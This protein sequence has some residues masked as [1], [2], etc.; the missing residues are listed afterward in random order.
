MWS[1]AYPAYLLVVLDPFTSIFRY[2]IPL[3]PL[4]A[5]LI[6]AAGRPLWRRWE[7]WA[8]ARFGVLLL[9]FVVGQ[10]YWIDILWRFVPPTDYPP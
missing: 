8:W 10:W 3:F 7:G 4:A 5:V 1:L 6:G 2:L 9:A